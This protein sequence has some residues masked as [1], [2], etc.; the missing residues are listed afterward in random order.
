MF[1][2]SAFRA[3]ILSSGLI[4]A[5]DGVAAVDF[6]DFGADHA[7]PSGIS[8]DGSVVVGSLGEFGGYTQAF[9]W[10]LATGIDASI[11]PSEPFSEIQSATGTSADGSVIVGATNY[12]GS[13]FRWTKESGAVSLGP[14]PGNGW[15]HPT[16]VSADGSVITGYAG[17]TRGT[18]AFRW[19]AQTGMVELGDFNP[20]QPAC[21]PTAISADGQVIVGGGHSAPGR[22]EAFRWTVSTGFVGL[23]F[24]PGSTPQQSRATGVSGDGSVIIGFTGAGETLQA[25]RWT[26]ETGQVGLGGPPGGLAFGVSADGGVIVGQNRDGAFIWDVDH[27]VRSLESVLVTE[28]VDLAGWN[29]FRAVAVSGDGRTIVGL[30]VHSGKKRGWIVSLDAPPSIPSISTA[31]VAPPMLSTRFKRTMTTVSR[32][33]TLSGIVRGRMTSV[34]YRVNRSR[35]SGF[36]SGG[37]DWRF[38]IPLRPGRNVINVFAEGPG[39][40]AKPVRIVVIRR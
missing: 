3:I 19:T 6:R 22:E 16:A 20:I 28:G 37:A 21:F 39:G 35:N 17:G 33:I 40:N 4:F 10:T 14:F 29:L 12:L 32:R 8:A 27:G 15:A 1:F 23:G 34:S 18:E 9:R 30:G 38:T 36:A 2:L 31:S 7:N 24:L 13:P 26:S 25:F 5:T 11:D